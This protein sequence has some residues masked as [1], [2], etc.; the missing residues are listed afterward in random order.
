MKRSE[1]LGEMDFHLHVG[2]NK[3]TT[4]KEHNEQMIVLLSKLFLNCGLRVHI[5][6]DEKRYKE[7][8]ELED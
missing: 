1:F 2:F 7:F 4:D 3:E 5:F 6:E 8:L